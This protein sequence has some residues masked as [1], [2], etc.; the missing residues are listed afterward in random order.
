MAS[1]IW[2][3]LAKLPANISHQIFAANFS[4]LFLQGF[5]P[6]QNIQRRRDDNKNK[7]SLLRG[8]G[9]IGATEE[10]CQKKLVFFFFS[11]GNAPKIKFLKVQMLL[12][13]NFVVIAQAPKHSP[14][15]FTPKIVGI[16]PTPRFLK[17]FLFT[18]ISAHGA[19][20]K[21]FSERSI[22]WRF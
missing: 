1:N 17:T 15:K 22:F 6:P 16:P 7:I 19:E 21:V 9:G 11:V 10:N 14:P 20:T 3:I 12:S 18:P 8:G 13:R 4:V 2:R 5:G